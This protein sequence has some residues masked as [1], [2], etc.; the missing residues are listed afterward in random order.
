LTTKP[1]YLSK[2]IFKVMKWYNKFDIEKKIGSLNCS[3]CNHT[4][5]EKILYFSDINNCPQC[6][7]KIGFISISPYHK[8]I[9]TID[10]DTSPAILR[11]I[12]DEL[13]SK[14]PKESYQELKELI[15]MLVSPIKQNID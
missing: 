8:F 11:L 15:L 9:Y 1:L 6:G 12:F 7:H 2:T 14:N 5:E 4:F 13:A 3:N 10:L